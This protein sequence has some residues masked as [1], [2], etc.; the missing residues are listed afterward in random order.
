M[1]TRRLIA[2][3][4]DLPITAPERD[5][6]RMMVRILAPR[7]IIAFVALLAWSWI[8]LEFV[9]LEPRY[10]D[11]LVELGGSAVIFLAAV[12]P[13]LRIWLMS[14]RELQRRIDRVSDRE[15]PPDADIG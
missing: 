11:R 12:F 14:E 4:R 15:S 7:L 1:S 3:M 13:V 6:I 9:V 8:R 2:L 5:A 10:L